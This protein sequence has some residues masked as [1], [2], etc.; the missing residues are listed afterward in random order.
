MEF[1]MNTFINTYRQTWKVGLIIVFAALAAAFFA[2][3]AGEGTT[4]PTQTT[5]TWVSEA[6]QPISGSNAWF[7]LYSV[8]ALLAD[9]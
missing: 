1:A 8:D 7:G 9:W 3:R 5:K 4:T 2:T 6:S